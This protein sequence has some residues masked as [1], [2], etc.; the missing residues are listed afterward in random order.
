M[1]VPIAAAAAPPVDDARAAAAGIRKLP[2]KRLTLY[3]DLAGEEIDRLPAVFEQAFPQWCRYFGVNESDHADW[4]VTG[5]LMKDKARFVAAGL[6]PADVPV[7]RAA[8]ITRD[9]T[10]LALRAADRLLSPRVAA[11][12]GDA[13]LHVHAVGQLRPAVVHGR[14]GGIPGHAPPG[15]TA[16]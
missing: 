12:R 15:K 6:L 8:A 1:L 11:A 14:A 13:R 4:H 5:C 7:P 3:T 9:D 10:S 16:G 2:G